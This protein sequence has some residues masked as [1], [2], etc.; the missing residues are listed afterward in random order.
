MIHYGGVAVQAGLERSMV[1]ICVQEVTQ[2]MVNKHL[3]LSICC[4]NVFLSQFLCSV[5]LLKPTDIV[6]AIHIYNN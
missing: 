4:F 5:R 6:K 1:R 2:V 3:N